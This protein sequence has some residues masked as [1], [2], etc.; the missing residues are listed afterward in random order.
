M[1]E[2]KRIKIKVKKRKLKIKR[3]LFL[4]LII[5]LF[6]LSL[7]FLKKVK[8]SNI[9]IVGNNIISDKEIIT[10]SHLDNYPSLLDIKTKKVTKYLLNNNYIK[11]VKIK[12][13]ITN[14]L[15][16]YIT[17]KKVLCKYQDKI[18]LED[19]SLNDDIYNINEAAILVSDINTIKDK[20]IKAFN[21]VDDNILIKISEIV[22]NPNDVDDERF[23]LYMNDGNLVYVTL[24]KIDKINKYNS[25]Y[26]SLDGKKG[27]V[28][29]D[30]GDYIEIKES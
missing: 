20:F 11:D 25:I 27:I 6:I 13:A 30:S 14:K 19:S 3:I 23:E 22:Y 9:Y 5:I 17:E 18:L 15:Y 26:S 8:V 28:Y 4:I 24:S 12:K 21:K 29:L 1:T 10:T 7:F 2:K 16:I